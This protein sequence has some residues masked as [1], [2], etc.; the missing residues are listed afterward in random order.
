MIS[1]SRL[2]F[3]MIKK[4]IKNKK[5]ERTERKTGK[6]KRNVKEE[7]EKDQDFRCN[8][9]FDMSILSIVNGSRFS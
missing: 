4:N 8:F 3:F 7:T 2:H 5:K 1:R 6:K 9:P